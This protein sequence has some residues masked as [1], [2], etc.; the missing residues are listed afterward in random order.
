MVHLS[1]TYA[2]E[3]QQVHVRE[4]PRVHVRGRPVV[5]W[6]LPAAGPPLQPAMRFQP[7]MLAVLDV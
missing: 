3:Q 1:Q 5:A 2:L 6:L 7:A 4:Q